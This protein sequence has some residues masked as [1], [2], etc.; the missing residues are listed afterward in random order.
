MEVA[1]TTDLLIVV[2]AA[3][4][5]TVVLAQITLV[6]GNVEVI[7]RWTA[8]GLSNRP[9]ADYARCDNCSPKL[10]NAITQ[11]SSD[12]SAYTRKT[13]SVPTAGSAT[14]YHRQVMLIRP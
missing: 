10:S 1:L 12:A 4:T 9:S 8:L 7:L 6:G 2:V 13:G 3:A 11:S 5:A 14:G